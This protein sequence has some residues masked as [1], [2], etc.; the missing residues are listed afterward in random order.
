MKVI[1]FVMQI[2]ITYVPFYLFAPDIQ[3]ILNILVGGLVKIPRNII[4]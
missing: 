3:G 4:H 1:A 2:S